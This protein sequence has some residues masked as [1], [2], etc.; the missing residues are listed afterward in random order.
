MADGAFQDAYR[1]IDDYGCIGD[2]RTAALV[3]S[4]GSID[5]LC[6]PEF[7]S[8]P[9]FSRLLDLR[10]GGFWRIQPTAPY[11]AGHRYLD[12]TNILETRFVATTGTARLLDFMPMRPL[13][14]RQREGG[15]D[16][17]HPARALIRVV[18]GIAGALDLESVCT[19]RPDFG[20]QKARVIVQDTLLSGA[21]CR[22]TGPT[23]WRVDASAPDVGK[24]TMTIKAG[25]RLAFILQ[26]EEEKAART[27]S[28]EEAMAL[29][30]ETCDFWRSWVRNCR[31][32]GPYKDAVVRSALALRLLIYGPTGAIVAAP[33]TSLPE[34]VGG[35][36]NW[37]YRYAWLRDASL[38]LEALLLAGF[39]DEMDA[40][41][42]WIARTIQIEKDT[43]TIMYPIRSGERIDEQELDDVEGYRGSR[44][45][46]I[47]N[48]ASGQVQ[49]DAYGAVLD[50]LHFA[51]KARGYDVAAV[52]EHFHSLADWV[53]DHWRE[54]GSG[55]WEV[56]A[57]TH[58]F[59]YSKAMTWVALDRAI[60]IAEGC[61][62]P[63]DVARWR[64]ECAKIRVEVL[65]R[66]WNAELGAFAQS[67]QD[68]WLDASNL[69]L[70]AM[71]FI[72]GDDPRMVATIDRTLDGL[73][74]NA[75]CYRYLQAP[76]A[77]GQ[78]GTFTVCSF[79]LVHALLLA[80]R[81]D[82]A[83]AMFEVILRDASPLGLYAEE[84]DAATRL[85]LG[86]FPQ[87]LSHI[88]LIGAAAALAHAGVA[89]SVAPEHADAVANARSSAGVAPA[90]AAN[91]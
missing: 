35:P 19:L 86:N 33:T 25:E 70:S 81:A 87:A 47:G 38:T 69:R 75:L 57:G 73:T 8:P 32:E 30:D 37:D 61:A 56:R 6:V 34:R 9:L 60:K 52:W 46:R 90:S 63:G 80:G 55:I 85:Q 71:G 91:D 58:D 42:D 12:E 31:Y 43:V 84:I 18:E 2:S 14:L 7:D 11:H 76:G 1:P 45:V 89:G 41:F 13:P 82:E 29:L 83:R 74:D 53:A 65:E 16:I 67:Y 4:S 5:W 27:I 72:A 23:P 3:G 40:A 28:Q 77:N 22:V 78:E 21:G 50:A 51:W 24:S 49:L 66:G 59:V 26:F 15:K 64:D 44:P 62:L 54:S 39:D 79:W 17:S 68:A 48:A 10:D 88:G 36:L 20:R